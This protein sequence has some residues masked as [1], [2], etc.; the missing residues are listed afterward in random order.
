VVSFKDLNRDGEC[1]D[2]FE[3]T[4]FHQLD[5]LYTLHSRLSKVVQPNKTG[6]SQ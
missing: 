6:Y 3:T 4:A 2:T 1:T 5:V